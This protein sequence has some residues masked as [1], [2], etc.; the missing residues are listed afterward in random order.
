MNPRILILAA[1]AVACTPQ[2]ALDKPALEDDE[3]PVVVQEGGVIACHTAGLRSASGPFE[4]R[5]EAMYVPTDFWTWSGG[6]TAADLDADGWLDVISVVEPGLDLYPGDPEG[7]FSSTGQAVFGHLEL[8]FASGTSVADYD[9]DGDLDLY[10][11]RVLGAPI[12]DFVKPDGSNRLLRNNGDGSF[13]DVTE[14]A[15]VDGCGVHHRTGETGC[16]RTMSSSWGDVDGDGDLDLF[17]GNYGEVDETDGVTQDEMSPAEPSFLYLNNGDGSFT[18]ASDVLPD[19]L[20]DGYTYSSALLDL[21][22]DGD[23]DLYTVNDFGMLWPNRVMW[24]DGGTLTFDPDDGSG[25]VLSMTGMGLGVADLNGD[26]RLDLAIPQWNANWLLESRVDGGYW[27]DVAQSKGFVPDEERN[28]LVGWG[29]EIA[30]LD[31]DGDLDMVTQFGHLPTPNST[32][33]NPEQQADSVVV[34]EPD[35]DGGYRFVDVSEQWMGDDVGLSRGAVLVDLNRDGWLDIAKRSLDDGGIMYISRCGD[36]SFATVHLRQPGTMNQ[37]AVGAR[38]VAQVGGRTMSR[39][40]FGGGTGYASQGAPELHFGLGDAER[41]DRL[42]VFWPDGKRS[43]ITDVAARQ[44][45]TLVR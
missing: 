38:V 10:V 15:G 7:A 12:P 40:L 41:I 35:G 16:F 37:F 17:V 29:T 22:G 1:G 18:D 34:N 21:D 13:S 25:L 33:W 11:N 30:D 43:V 24:N 6:I 23:L 28:Q 3:V 2:G 32:W 9:G 8:S 27:I 5:V 45:L 4:R 20:H 39:H 31:N 42:E 44:E 26:G 14:Q 19:E 36:E